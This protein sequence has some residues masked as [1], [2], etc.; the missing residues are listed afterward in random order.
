[1][2]EL[3]EFRRQAGCNQK[4]WE[5]AQNE[6]FSHVNVLSGKVHVTVRRNHHR[7]LFAVTSSLLRK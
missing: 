2:N 1:M 5:L 6:R 3:G 7:G 4:V